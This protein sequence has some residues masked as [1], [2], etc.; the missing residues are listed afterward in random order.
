MG[1]FAIEIRR[2]GF[3]LVVVGEASGFLVSPRKSGGLFYYVGGCIEC[4]CVSEG[5]KVWDKVVGL[6][7]R[8]IN[9]VRIL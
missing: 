8:V 5:K 9:P 6:F 2:S 3:N 1:K 4:E 7:V